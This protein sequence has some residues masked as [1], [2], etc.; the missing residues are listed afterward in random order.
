MILIFARRAINAEWHTAGGFF[1][2]V[3]VRD[4]K[5]QTAE[6]FW[7]DPRGKIFRA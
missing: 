7:A 3:F 1:I 6:M 5:Y 2:R 4:V